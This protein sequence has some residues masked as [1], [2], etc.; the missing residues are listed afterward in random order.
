MRIHALDR[1]QKTIVRYAEIVDIDDEE[2][3]IIDMLADVIQWCAFRG[4]NFS[5]AL[6]IAETHAEA[7]MNGED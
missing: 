7:E 6:R 4:V 5:E 3:V 1:A 2:D